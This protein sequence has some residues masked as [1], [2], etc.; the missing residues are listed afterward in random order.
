MKITGITSQT[1]NDNRVN[2]MVD[3]AYRFS[4]DI[5]QLSDLGI[6]IGKE[7]T[8]EELVELESESQFGKLYART[9]EYCL[10]RPHSAKEVRDY[11]YKKTRDT[12]TKT[13]GI[14]KGVPVEITERVFAR[15]ADKGYIDDEK[16]A[17]FWVENRNTTKGSSR[18][19]IIAEL[20]AKGVE[21]SLVER[22]WEDSERS[23][24]NELQKIIAKK[25][26]RYPDDQKFMQYLARQGFSYD[27][28]KSALSGD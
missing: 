16:F 10:M 28:I 8:E 26:N 3:G 21:S 23:D 12:R 4:L 18:R 17:R 22:L 6:R 11:L 20:R 7:Y 13:G 25:R 2:V 15:L 24:E 1:K 27:D 9:L 19:K 14:K 5:F